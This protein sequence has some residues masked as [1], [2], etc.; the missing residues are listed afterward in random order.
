MPDGQQYE[1]WLK[2]K[3]NGKNE[4]AQ[5]GG[6]PSGGAIIRAGIIRVLCTSG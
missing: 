4:Q 6:L 1:D 2:S 3:E 5:P